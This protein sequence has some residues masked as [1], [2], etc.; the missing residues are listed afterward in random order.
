[1]QKTVLLINKGKSFM[2]VT[3]AKSFTDAGYKVVEVEPT[4]GNYEE[5]YRRSQA[6]RH[7]DNQTFVA[8]EA[9]ILVVDDTEMNLTVVKGLL[10]RTQIQIDTAVSG[11]QCIDMVKKNTYDALFLDHRMP[12]MD[13]IETLAELKKLT[14]CPNAIRR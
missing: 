11:Y 7:N 10:K 5:A 9:R 2:V 3:I 8:S 12:G 4:M 1:M 6:E 14:D 13:G